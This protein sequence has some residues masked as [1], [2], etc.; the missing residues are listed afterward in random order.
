M[1]KNGHLDGMAFISKP[2][3]RSALLTAL[4]EAISGQKETHQPPIVKSNIPHDLSQELPLRI[5]LV[6]DN[7]VNQKVAV[8]ILGRM[9][10]RVDV[11]GNGLEALA[12]LRARSYDVLLMD[13][14][15]PQMDGLET[16][17]HIHRDWSE[18][19]R[20]YIIALTANAMQEDQDKCLAVGMN[21][22]IRKP[23]QIT[24]L[25]QALWRAYDSIRARLT[26]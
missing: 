10:Y 17:R 22:Y 3:R 13:I 21:D 11:A 2:L 1:L 24:A 14:Q 20:P 23:L 8:K 25:E 19:D 15:M 7:A 9:G 18:D 6:E 4:A 5:L 26:V 12:A 16:T